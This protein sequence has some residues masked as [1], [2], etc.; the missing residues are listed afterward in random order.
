MSPARRC[1]PPESRF[2]N[3]WIGSVAIIAMVGLCSGSQA[4]GQAYTWNTVS[5]GSWNQNINWT[6]GTSFPNGLNDTAT[7]QQDVLGAT[8][9]DLNAATMLNRLTFGDSSGTSPYT[10][11]PNG[12]SLTFRAAQSSGDA[13]FITSSNGANAITAAITSD[14]ATVRIS[15]TGGGTLSLSSISS[16]RGGG[17]VFYDTS[18]KVLAGGG[19]TSVNGIGNVFA[20][21]AASGA[22]PQNWVTYDT[23][24]GAV[25]QFTS[26]VGLV[27]ATGTS[28]V[29]QL[30]NNNTSLTVSTT[31]NSFRWTTNSTGATLALG[32]NDMTI[33][34]GGFLRS[35]PPNHN[36]TVA[37]TGGKIKTPVG[38]PL[39]VW[40]NSSNN[41]TLNAAVDVDGLNVY[42]RLTLGATGSAS[43]FGTG[44]INVFG[45][46][47]SLTF[48]YAAPSLSNNVNISKESGSQLS[49]APASSGTMTL[50]G[51][52]MVNGVLTGNASGAYNIGTL[53][54]YGSGTGTPMTVRNTLAPGDAGTGTLDLGNN[55]TLSGSSTYRVELGGTTPGDGKGFYDQVSMTA[56]T[57]AITLNTGA[58]LDISLA[59]GFI[60][61]AIDNFYILSRAD[62]AVWA[63]KFFGL[64]EGATVTFGGGAYSGKITYLANWSGLQS[65][66]TLTGGNDV[67][68]FNVN[69]IPVPE[70]GTISLV[71]LG[72]LVLAGMHGRR[73]SRRSA[74]AGAYALVGIRPAAW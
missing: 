46:G 7:I 9:I 55:L 5:G 35:A 33:I 48:Q 12:G 15:N 63:T 21:Y 60:P 1:A 54:G 19:M 6:P 3:P 71:A 43:T 36:T 32:T 70:P 18:T 24:T 4:L 17:Y 29:T 37:S 23:V 74:R 38:V 14:N 67:A 62:S 13:P 2:V 20:T 51:T 41:M 27:G 26:Y 73:R 58:A 22:S 10:I 42:G 8:A 69:V 56:I 28:N 65:T 47:Y 31:M 34:S 45:G 50:S 57:G 16:A 11:T 64:D 49:F 44:D 61:S 52:V 66:S 25:G 40:Q 39:T 53:T 68:L 30:T 72:G 59:D